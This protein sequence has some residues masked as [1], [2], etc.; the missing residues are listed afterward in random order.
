MY[1]VNVC[2][3]HTIKWGMGKKTDNIGVF[4]RGDIRDRGCD[5]HGVVNELLKLKY[6]SELLKRVVLFNNK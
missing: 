2:K 4:V 6:P 1:Y 5:W 3:F